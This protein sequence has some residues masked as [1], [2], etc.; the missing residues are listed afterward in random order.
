[1][2][3]TEK[4]PKKRRI[5][6]NKNKTVIDRNRIIRIWWSQILCGY[7]LW[8]SQPVTMHTFIGDEIKV[9][10]KTSKKYIE[11]RVWLAIFVSSKISNNF[12]H[13]LSVLFAVVTQKLTTQHKYF[14]SHTKNDRA[15][16]CEQHN[17]GYLFIY[18]SCKSL[19]MNEKISVKP[20][21]I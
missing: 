14:I 3:D 15:K 5:K 4:Y 2:F 10:K 12:A 16:K 18:A 9:E 21:A 19:R 20:N 11:F 1:M 13:F 17:F 8:A 6:I 7:V